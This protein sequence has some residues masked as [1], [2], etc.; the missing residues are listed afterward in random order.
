M[1]SPIA[2]TEANRSHDHAQVSSGSRGN[3]REVTLSDPSFRYTWLIWASAFML[4]WA[5]LFI[6]RPALRRPM[7][8]ASVLAA[9]FGLT[10]PLFVPVYW[11]PPSL[12]DLAQRTG[13]DIES[14]VFSFAIGGL[15]VAGYRALTPALLR[16]ID[17]SA[18][19]SPRHCR[20]LMA[21]AS[22]FF[23][24]FGLIPGT[25]DSSTGAGHST[26]LAC[27]SLTAA[28]G[29][30][31]SPLRHRRWACRRRHGSPRQSLLACRDG[32]TRRSCGDCQT[33]IK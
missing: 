15:G 8:W 9:P 32:A 17:H 3:A 10:E 16:S 22:P 11:N 28:P 2:V 12:F 13:L 30:M 27:C 4:P 21:L 33:S 5:L 31:C 6:A 18:R 19:S 24:F 25:S 20:H 23:F 7:L 1:E 14:L 26:R 29:R